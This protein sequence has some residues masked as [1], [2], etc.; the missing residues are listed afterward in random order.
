MSKREWKELPDWKNPEDYEFLVG[1]KVEVWAWEFLRRNPVYRRCWNRVGHLPDVPVYRP[2]KKNGETVEAWQCRVYYET[3]VTPTPVLFQAYFGR[4]WGLQQLSDPF[5][6]YSQK[7]SFK[8]PPNDF[9]RM[10]FMPEEFYQLVED[11]E[12][13]AMPFLRVA[14]RYAV[15]AYDLMQ[16]ITAQTTK[17]QQMLFRWHE[18][19]VQSERIE[20]YESHASKT[21]KWQ[22]HLQAL[23]A[24]RT[25]PRPKNSEIGRVLKGDDPSLDYLRGQGEK[26]LYAAKAVLKNHERILKFKG[27]PG[28]D[29]NS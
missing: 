27:T 20:N 26:I 18:E 28:K 2:R 11:E 7:V 12:E 24:E 5:L 29:K 1:A 10:I 19:M 23:D 17:A 9:P 25:E 3:G 22:R 16:P 6:P 14:N 4:K 21:A 8:P 13:V 15:V